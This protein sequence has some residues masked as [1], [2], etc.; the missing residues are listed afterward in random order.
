MAYLT[1]N[2]QRI[3]LNFEPQE[4]KKGIPFRLSGISIITTEPNIW[5]KSK[6]MYLHGTIYT[7]RYIDDIGGFISFKFNQKG[8]FISKL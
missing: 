6:K 3:T 4:D 1:V 7:F 2:N 5:D 8:K